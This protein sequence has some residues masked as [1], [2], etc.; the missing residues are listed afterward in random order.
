MLHYLSRVFF[1]KPK[2]HNRDILSIKT[3]MMNPGTKSRNTSKIMSIY[4][5]KPGF[6]ALLPVMS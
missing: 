5:T 6:T 2:Y 4:K 1:V 3:T